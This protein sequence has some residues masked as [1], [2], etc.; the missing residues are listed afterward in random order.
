MRSE[1]DE[2]AENVEVLEEPAE[3]VRTTF[4]KCS[5]RTLL[6]E[7]LEEGLEE[8]LRQARADAVPPRNSPLT[9]YACAAMHT[10]ES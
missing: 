9:T 7:V 6:R 4:W 1:T 5:P 2:F 3:V 10:Q 8:A